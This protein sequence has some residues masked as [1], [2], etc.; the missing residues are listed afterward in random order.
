[1]VMSV[2]NGE[3]YMAEAVESILAQTFGDFEFVIIDDGSTDATAAMLANYASRD[4]RVRVFSQENIGRAESL[5]R[6]M[7]LAE[8][9]LIAR[10]DADD[11]ALPER[12]AKQIEFLRTR[13]EIGL[14]GGTV[15]F[16]TPEGRA[17]GVDR[18]PRCCDTVRFD[19]RA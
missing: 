11:V 10:M 4:E 16:I 18:A 1:V 19:I 6:G 14:L 12:F 17:I 13:R 8:A 9:A 2:F 5:N 3:A 7:Q 15:E